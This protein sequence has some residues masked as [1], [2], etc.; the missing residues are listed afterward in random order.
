MRNPFNST[1]RLGLKATRVLAVALALSVVACNS[2]PDPVNV[3]AGWKLVDA[4]PFSFWAPPDLRD[5]PLTGV[6]IDSYVREFQ[7]KDLVISFD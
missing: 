7:G 5:L 4:G 3:P 1:R 6:P 2:V